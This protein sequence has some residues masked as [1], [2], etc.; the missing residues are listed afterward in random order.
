MSSGPTSLYTFFDRFYIFW[1]I[2]ASV[3]GR[4]LPVML[5]PSVV[6]TPFL[7]MVYGVGLWVLLF[8]PYALFGVSGL[9]VWSLLAALA[10][11]VAGSYVACVPLFW[12]DI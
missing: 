2:Y 5:P 4:A 12:S 1:G 8:Y 9:L 6:N 3:G 10:S 7:Q 11:E